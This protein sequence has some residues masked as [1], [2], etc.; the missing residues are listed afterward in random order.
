MKKIKLICIILAAILA[1]GLITNIITPEDEPLGNGGSASDLP[2]DAPE[3]SAEFSLT[4]W[5]TSEH[6]S[7]CTPDTVTCSFCGQTFPTEEV[8][9]G[10][11]FY[12]AMFSY[13]YSWSYPCP[14]C[15]DYDNGTID[16]VSIHCLVNGKCHNCDFVCS[17][18]C[19]DQ[20]YDSNYRDHLPEEHPIRTNGWFEYSDVVTFD[21][22]QD[23]ICDL[24]G[25][26]IE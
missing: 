8:E 15:F 23:G 14:E 13:G 26:N 1:V 18:T 19:V 3:I 6:G 9:S 5:H 25:M 16:V 4:N 20:D 21:I 7:S 2:Q 17:H 22:V 10:D 12:G 24:C 11:N